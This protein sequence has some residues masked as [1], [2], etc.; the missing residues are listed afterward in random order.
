VDETP[1]FATKEE[2]EEAFKNLLKETVRQPW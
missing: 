2:A 1:E